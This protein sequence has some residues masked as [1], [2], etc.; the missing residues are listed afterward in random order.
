MK[1]YIYTFLKRIQYLLSLPLIFFK[2]IKIKECHKSKINIVID[3]LYLFI[4]LKFYPQGYLDVGLWDVNRSEFKYYYGHPNSLYARKKFRKA[5]QDR[6]Y[7]ALFDNK[8]ITDL[9]LR[10]LTKLIPK[11]LGIIKPSEFNELYINKVLDTHKC[12]EIIIKPIEG[13]H[14]QDVIKVV[15][16]DNNILIHTNKTEVRLKDFELSEMSIAQEYVHQNSNIEQIYRSSINTIRMHTLLTKSNDVLILG[17]YMRFGMGGNI[18]DNVGAGGV[19]VGI[20]PESG[21]LGDVG[22]D[23]IAE[24]YFEHPDTKFRFS[25]F[26]VPYWEEIKKLAIHI[27]ASTFFYKFLGMDIA[28]SQNGPVLIELNAN[29]EMGF[30]ELFPPPL[31]KNE[32]ILKEFAEYDLLYNKAQIELSA[33]IN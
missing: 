5:V 21:K 25:G 31:L 23:H 17:S 12:D 9:Y 24:K 14:G 10:G 33:N 15:R 28:V 32:K 6:E 26:S 29:P 22:Y 20:K 11:F 18:V 2:T 30:M 13:C 7:Q 1:M 8:Y 27:Q 16:S 3:L 19:M 4:R